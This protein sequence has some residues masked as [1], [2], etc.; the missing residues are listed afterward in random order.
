MRQGSQ[1]EPLSF[2]I[3]SL[4]ALF[5]DTEALQ[6]QIQ[7]HAARMRAC[8]GP[9]VPLGDAVAQKGERLRRSKVMQSVLLCFS[10]WLRQDAA[11]EESSASST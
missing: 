8:P 9:V 1:L 7:A 3:L 10:F 11:A 6:H 2:R 4:V 5:S